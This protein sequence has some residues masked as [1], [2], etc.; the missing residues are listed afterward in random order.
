MCRFIFSKAAMKTAGMPIL[1]SDCLGDSLRFSRRDAGLDE[2]GNDKFQL[3]HPGVVWWPGRDA[4]PSWG[5]Q[6]N[7]CRFI[8]NEEARYAKLRRAWNCSFGAEP[9]RAAL[10]GRFAASRP[11]SSTTKYMQPSSPQP[12]V[13]VLLFGSIVRIHHTPS[14]FSP[15]FCALNR[16]PG[17]FR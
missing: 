17:Q 9:S 15:V 3:G 10:N 12:R 5:L 6:L 14:A 2:S 16:P 11:A 7:L 8:D 4:N 13:S 1:D